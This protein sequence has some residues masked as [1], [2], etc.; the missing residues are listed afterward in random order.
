[1]WFDF[2]ELFNRSF[3]NHTCIQVLDLS[4]NELGEDYFHFLN[5]LKSFKPFKFLSL[6]DN[7]NGERLAKR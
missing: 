5:A 6:R 1:M 7:K 2:E 3:A 4:D